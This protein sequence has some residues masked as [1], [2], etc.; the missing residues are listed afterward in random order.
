MGNPPITVSP[1]CCWQALMPVWEGEGAFH[2]S[3]FLF[4]TSWLL[5]MLSIFYVYWPSGFPLWWFACLYNLLFSIRLFFIFLL[6][7]GV[8]YVLWFPIFCLIY[9]CHHFDMHLCMCTFVYLV[10]L[11]FYKA[12]LLAFLEH[13]YRIKKFWCQIYQSFPLWFVIFF[14]AF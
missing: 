8:L 5:M 1:R 12:Y 6:I 14:S 3:E 9:M 11:Q 13:F 10:L 2:C 4:N 7:C